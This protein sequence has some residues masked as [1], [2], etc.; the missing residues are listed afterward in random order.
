M[1]RSLLLCLFATGCLYRTTHIAPAPAPARTQP[2]I[3]VR[4]ETPAGLSRVVIDV[5]DG[6]ASVDAVERASIGG[7]AE[8]GYRT[9]GFRG[10]IVHRRRVCNSTPCVVDTTPGTHEL[11]FTLLGAPDRTSTATVTAFR[12]PSVY[13]HAMGR[14][15]DRSWKGLV[16]APLVLGGITTT[17]FGLA[18]AKNDRV[19]E[20]TGRLVKPWDGVGGYALAG[21]G[22]AITALGAWLLHG[23]VVEKQPASSV[24][25]HP[26]L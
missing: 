20:M 7:T 4:D 6:P 3:D 16:G 11:R 24:Q 9:A 10:S 5:V 15:R 13:R 21:A 26:A 18:L 12:D 14:T 22:V 23:S 19:D 17:V 2:A 1:R 25:W 8:V